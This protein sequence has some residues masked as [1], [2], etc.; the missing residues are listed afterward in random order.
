MADESVIKFKTQSE[1][2]FATKL[3]LNETLFNIRIKLEDN[4]PE[5]SSFIYQDGTKILKEDE[6][7]F[8]LK[9]IA[10]KEKHKKNYIVYLDVVENNYNQDQSNDDGSSS[11]SRYEEKFIDTTEIKKKYKINSVESKNIKNF[12]DAPKAN[13]LNK[14]LYFPKNI[15]KVNE[16]D[17][18]N[19][20]YIEKI[21][22]LNIYLYSSVHF[23]DIEE[24]NALSIMV[25]GKTGSGKTS[26]LN[27]FVNSLLGVEYE[28]N[29]RFKIISEKSGRSQA[30]SQTDK[31][32][33]YNIRSIEGYPPMKIIDTP[34][35]EDT[36]GLK[37]DEET[38][39]Q[40]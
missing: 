35:Y 17:L 10:K 3:S 31:V 4:L 1:A 37:K 36:R 5:G 28:D 8:T 30:Y 2:L 29:Y 18:S 13:Y 12:C 25:V 15:K 21:G 26:L 34:G 38:T 27:S 40:N 23:E 9:D 24:L 22:E 16:E 19:F 14:S 11:S 32:N 39:S 20:K 7:K 6:N 33:Y